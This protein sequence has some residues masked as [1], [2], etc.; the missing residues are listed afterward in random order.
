MAATG[1]DLRQEARRAR[2][3]QFIVNFTSSVIA[4]GQMSRA[5]GEALV[6]AARAKILE[7]FPGLDDTYELLYARRFMRLLDEFTLAAPQDAADS[8][9]PP[10]PGPGYR[11]KDALARG[12]VIPFPG[13]RHA[14]AVAAGPRPSHFLPAH[15]S[16]SEDS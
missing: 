12:V 3:V 11:K 14:T 7:C 5:D 10:G 9:A 4:E 1:D 15:L 16:S 2:Y 6:E 13:H 8:S